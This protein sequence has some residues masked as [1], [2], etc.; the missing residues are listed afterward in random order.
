MLV[1]SFTAFKFY[2]HVNV[3]WQVIMRVC[4]VFISCAK[5]RTGWSDII[6]INW[7]YLILFHVLLAI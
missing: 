6:E 7:L 5:D 3:K 4:G 1:I 2:Y